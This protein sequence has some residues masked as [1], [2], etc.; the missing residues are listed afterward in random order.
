MWSRIKM[1]ED[2]YWSW[3]DETQESNHS[4]LEQKTGR[5]RKRG[6]SWDAFHFTSVVETTWIKRASKIDSFCPL[7][8]TSRN[9]NLEG[10]FA[11][12]G[13]KV[14]EEP[15]LGLSLQSFSFVLNMWFWSHTQ[16]KGPKFD[17]RS[18]NWSPQATTGDPAC[19]NGD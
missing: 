4:Y 13:Y 8:Y 17:P 10:H 19:Q 12:Q 18:G 16:R 11:P 9:C 6:I 2:P 3:A 15:G 14:T 5:W 1:K 7:F